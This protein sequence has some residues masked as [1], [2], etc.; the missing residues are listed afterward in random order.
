MIEQCLGMAEKI[1]ALQDGELATE[2]RIQVEEHLRICQRCRQLLHDYQE[3]ISLTGEALCPNQTRQVDWDAMWNE[4]E[5]AGLPGPS[6][7]KGLAGFFRSR[8]CW[9]RAGVAAAC[10]GVV[11]AALFTL[12]SPGRDVLLP[13]SRVESVASVTG[14]VMML[15]TSDGQ[16]IIWILPDKGRD[17]S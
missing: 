1:S 9:L 8:S 12:W 17:R 10:A 16:P 5:A 15:Q 11:A 6:P 13:G 7:W 4:I 14:Q 2:E 3:I